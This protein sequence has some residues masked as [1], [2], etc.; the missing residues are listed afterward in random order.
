MVRYAAFLRG[1]APTNPNM[2]NAKLREVFEQLGLENVQT[3][4]TSGNVLFE[5]ASQ[6]SPKLE[7]MIEQALPE[8][9]GF[10]SSSFI[11]SHAELQKVAEHNVFKAEKESKNVRLIVA[12]TRNPVGEKGETP[13]RADAEGFGILGVYDRAIYCR[14]DLTAAKTPQLMRWLDKEFSKELTTRT[15]NTVERILKKL[16]AYSDQKRD[17]HSRLSL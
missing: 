7:A 17:R 2:R 16:D 5:S 9:L 6:D 11:L 8:Q 15:W 4:I 10:Q 12:F 1:I 3:V 14:V 13:Q